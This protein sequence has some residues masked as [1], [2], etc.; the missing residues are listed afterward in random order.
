VGTRRKKKLKWLSVGV[1]VSLRK[2]RQE[3][4]T[5]EA[6]SPSGKVKEKKN[7]IIHHVLQSRGDAK[8]RLK[9]DATGEK[10]EGRNNSKKSRPLKEK[11]EAKEASWRISRTSERRSTTCSIQQKG[12][13]RN[14]LKSEMKGFR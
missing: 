14:E 8:G 6:H 4:E 10:A 9:E 13:G 11:G 2:E 12:R 7:R 3:G 5:C 1:L